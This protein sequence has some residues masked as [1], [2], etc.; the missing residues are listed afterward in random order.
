[1]IDHCV[2]EQKQKQAKKQYAYYIAEG[3][4]YISENVANIRGGGKYL[5]KGLPWYDNETETDLDAEEVIKDTM[6]RLAKLG[7]EN[8]KPF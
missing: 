8:N 2:S 7:G 1:M 6:S 3:I 4:R 5:A